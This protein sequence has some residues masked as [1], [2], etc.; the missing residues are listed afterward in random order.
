MK[1]APKQAEAL[2]FPVFPRSGPEP[3]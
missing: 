1:D 2:L 3:R